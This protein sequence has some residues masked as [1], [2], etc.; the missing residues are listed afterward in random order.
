MNRDLDLIAPAPAAGRR[1]DPSPGPEILEPFWAP[2][3]RIKTERILGEGIG[4]FDPV[5]LV[6]EAD[7]LVYLDQSTFPT[8]LAVRLTR[9]RHLSAKLAGSIIEGAFGSAPLAGGSWMLLVTDILQIG[10][11]CL[12]DCPF[13]ERRLFR[14]EVVTEIMALRASIPLL[15]AGDPDLPGIY[16]PDGR[17]VFSARLRIDLQS[18]YT[19]DGRWRYLQPPRD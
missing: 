10:D 15:D 6:A 18:P 12:M 11:L 2:L 14:R 1:E 7:G 16:T 4:R 8:G 17:A 5:L 9:G 19:P 3:R 13:A